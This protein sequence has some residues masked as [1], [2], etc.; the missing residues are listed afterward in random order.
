MEAIIS[1]YFILEY[2]IFFICI[3]YPF[4]HTFELFYDILLFR[5]HLDW[6]YCI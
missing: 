1:R 4:C 3:Y 5:V 6:P 2:L